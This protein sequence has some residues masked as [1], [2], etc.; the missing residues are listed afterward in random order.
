[1]RVICC[2]LDCVWEDKAASHAR[3]RALLAASPVPEG[4]LLVLPEMFS[5]GFSMD[6]EAIHEGEARE[7]ERFLAQTAREHRI[8]VTGGVV[9]RGADGRGRNQSLTFDPA[10]QEIARYSKIHPFTLG[11]ETAHYSAGESPV[12]FSCGEFRIAPFVCYDLRFP[13]IFRSS[14]RRGAQLYTVIASWPQTR[15]EHWIALLRARAIEN[16]VYVVGVNRC[17]ADPRLTYNGRTLIVDPG[18]AI[19]ADAGNGECL[20]SADLDLAALQEYRRALPFLVDI[21]PEF[22]AQ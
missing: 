4:A 13:E 20:V 11:A 7:S 5:T 10:G 9:T 2:Q 15:I 18:G 3:V 8:F 12:V 22:V 6:V 21:H 1:M 16:Q 17:G 19:L 14:V